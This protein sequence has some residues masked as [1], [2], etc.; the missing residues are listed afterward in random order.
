MNL[1][2]QEDEDLVSFA[3]NVSQQCERFNLKDLSI[4]M[5]KCLV[6]VRGLTASCNKDIRL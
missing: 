4:D 1:R 3:G 6:F 5:F 2:K